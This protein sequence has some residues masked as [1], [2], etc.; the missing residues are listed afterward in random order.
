MTATFDRDD[1]VLGDLA[2]T[3]HRAVAMLVPA[4]E[5]PPAEELR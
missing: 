4:L 2:A 1:R 5:R 3:L